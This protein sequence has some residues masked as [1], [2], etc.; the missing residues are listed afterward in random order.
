MSVPCAAA[1]R[2]L[3][4]PAM[5]EPIQPVPPPVPVAAAPPGFTRTQPAP[6]SAVASWVLYDLANTMFSMGVISLYFPQWVRAT[7]GAESADTVVTL[8]TSLSMFII[9][10]LSPL[11]GA[12]SDRAPRR[13]PFLVA[14][15]VLSVAFTLMLGRAGL[16]GTMIAFVIANA[17]YQA[18]LQFYDS[19]L[20]EVSTEENRGRIGGIGVGVGY[21]GSY[22]AV[23]LGLILRQADHTLLFTLVGIGFLAFAIPCFFFVRERGNPRPGR[24]FDLKVI[25]ESTRR[26]VA[27]LRQGERYPGLVRFLVGRVFYTDAINTVIMVMV[28][29]AANVLVNSGQSDAGAEST[30][31]VVILFAISFAMLGGFIWGRLVDRI[32]PKRTLDAVLYLWLVTFSLA[33]AMAL[34]ALPTFTLWA[35]AAMAGIGLGGIWSADRPLML[36]LTPPDRVGEFYGLYGM[37]GRF[38]AIIGPL[39]WGGIFELMKALGYPELV[40]QGVGLIML[41]IMVLVSRSILRKVDDRPR[42]WEKLQTV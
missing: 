39:L 7:F 35:V 17:A 6:T 1:R 34:F 33:S 42:D 23:G 32:G 22:I 11:I 21:F 24:V 40:G 18:G 38:S 41:L 26:T 20:V 2:D 28:L 16:V 27:T 3:S 8:I 10:V 37:V 5:T 31:R 9:F 4:S 19:L 25:G 13:M 36:R 15:T 12:M 29:V 14:S 30:A